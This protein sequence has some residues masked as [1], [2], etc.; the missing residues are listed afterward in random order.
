MSLSLSLYIYIHTYTYICPCS[1]CFCC[2]F[3]IA[4]ASHRRFVL[5]TKG[6]R[7]RVKRR[8]TLDLWAPK[9]QYN[10]ATAPSM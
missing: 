3:I 1:V 10:P 4:A 7:A 9:C 2:F 5:R 8:G 6:E